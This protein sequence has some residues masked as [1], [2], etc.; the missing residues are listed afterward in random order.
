MKLHFRRSGT[1]LVLLESDI[2]KVF[3]NDESVNEVLRVIARVVRRLTPERNSS[4][5][6][7]QSNR[8]LVVKAAERRYRTGSGSDRNQHSTSTK[9]L[10]ASEIAF[11]G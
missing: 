8:K 7:G 2:R 3:R 4:G 11:A 6:R 9:D 10:M 5:K 1:N